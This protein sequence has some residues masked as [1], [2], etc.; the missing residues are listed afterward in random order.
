MYFPIFIF[1]LKNLFFYFI[2]SNI[3]IAATLPETIAHVKAS[4]VGVGTYSSI[5]GVQA[6]YSGTG[7]VVADGLHVVTNAHVLPEKIDTEHNEYIGVFVGINPKLYRTEIVSVDSIH[8][9][10]LLK[11]NGPT[12]PHFSLGS[13]QEVKEGMRI[14]FTGFPIGP[15][16]GLYPVTHRGIVSAIVPIATAGRNTRDL[17]PQR[18]Q[19]LS[20]KPFMVFQLDATAYPGNSGSPLYDPSTGKVLGVI[21]MVFVKGSRENV[22]KDPSGITYAIPVEHVYALLKDSGLTP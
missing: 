9:L 20:H 12:L 5:R 13:M 19:Q 4:V 15:V 6:S 17:N 22:L 3:A 18:I 16:L 10:A 11:I 7:F 1:L 2:F 21:N 14:A 8:D